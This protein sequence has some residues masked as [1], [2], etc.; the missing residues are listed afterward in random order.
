MVA[1]MEMHGIACCV[2][3]GYATPLINWYTLTVMGVK[4]VAT[5]SRVAP[6]VLRKF[7]LLG[8]RLVNR[9]PFDTPLES[10]PEEVS[11]V[12]YCSDVIPLEE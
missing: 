6:T 12:G 11:A 2:G 10:A 4:E 8:G 3:Y 1:C 7:S 5:Q 9:G